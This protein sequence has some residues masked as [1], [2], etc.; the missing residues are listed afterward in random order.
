MD[1]TDNRAIWD[2]KYQE[3]LPSL[4]RPDPFFI[5]VY[6]RLVDQAFPNAG[7]ALDLAAGLGRHA[8]WL[9]ER[10][11]QVSAVDV[12]EVAIGKLSQTA[13]QLNVKIKLFAIDAAEYDFDTA[14]F[15]LIVLFYHLDRTLFPKIVSALNPG[16]LFICKMAVS[17]GPQIASPTGNFKPLGKN[18]LASLVPDLQAVTYHERPV[19]ARRARGTR[20]RTPRPYLARTASSLV[21][22]D[23]SSASTA[24]APRKW[25]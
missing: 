16:G 18:E 5:S 11:W 7:T 23:A 10:A 15:D 2:R 4:A 19:T 3:G 14:R 6:E 1:D 12:S 8:L 9:A 22:K 24:T 13:A 25:R 20:W 17:W 21:V